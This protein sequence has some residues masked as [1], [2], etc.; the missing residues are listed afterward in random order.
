MKEKVVLIGAGS[1][2]FTR[3]LVADLLG[4]EWE[5]ELALI[6]I[7][8]T[9]LAVAE[10]L[11]RKMVEAKRARVKLSATLDRREALPGATVVICTVGVG[12]RRAW[13]QDVLIPRQFGIYQ[14]VG[15]SVLPGG[16]SRALR[17][18]PAMV[19]IAQD[20]LDLA[21]QALFFN[22]G[23]PM[24][25]VCRA[26]R[27]ATGANVVGLCHGVFGVARELA[28]HLGVDFPRLRYTAVG[29][30]HLTWFTEVRVDGQDSMPRLLEVAAAKL[31][32][33]PEVEQLGQ[34]FAEAG[35]A[36]E[37]DAL[38]DEIN[39]FSW[40]LTQLFHAYPAVND[41][42]VTEFFPQLFA[43]ERSYYGRTLGVDTFSF[44]RTIAWGDQGFQAMQEMALS[45]DPLP[46]DYFAR[47]SGEHE[48]V[49]DIIESI[50][51]DAG[52]VYSANLPNRGQVPNLPLDAVL[53]SPA[54][55]DGGGVRAIAQPP[56][57]AGLV[58]TL[59]TR[60]AWVET[61]VEAALE[62]SRDKFIQA[63]LLDGAVDSV[64]TAARLADAL[65]EAQAA[66]LPQFRPA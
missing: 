42:H 55:A 59:A 46:A 61:V 47:R 51:S 57:A 16:T 32:R 9:A 45:Q 26:I 27:K 3:G 25:P 29:V 64:T 56:L 34:R 40:Q 8:P 19:A 23:N 62:G 41:R 15:D 44:E 30:N 1:A 35:A 28:A 11:A 17:M 52:R 4:R 37:A 63:L 65:L 22:Y 54:V 7:D 20:V 38:L 21:P 53:E 2:S 39:P 50:R 60:L 12:G 13:E 33:L 36:P 58:G 6:D 18:I 14:P 48:Q 49:V 10:G 24:P 5:M 43:K 66:Y 31:A